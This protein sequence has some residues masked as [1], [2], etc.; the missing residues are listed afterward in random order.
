MGIANYA[1]SYLANAILLKKI[2][3]ILAFQGR[4]LHNLYENNTLP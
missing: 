2:K 4:F 3:Q 1:M